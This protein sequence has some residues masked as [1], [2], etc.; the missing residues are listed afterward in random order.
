MNLYNTKLIVSGNIVEAYHYQ[1]PLYFGYKKISTCSKLNIIKK[2]YL[3]QKKYT[4][5]KAKNKIR[6]LINSNVNKYQKKGFRPFSPVFL[7]LT[8]AENIIDKKQALQ[9]F[10]NFIKRLNYEISKN[11]AT[12]KYSA[13]AEYQ[14]RGSVHF[15]VILYNFPFLRAERISKIWSFGYIKINKIEHVKQIGA[16]VSKYFSKDSF[17]TL[18]KYQKMFYSSQ[19]LFLPKSSVYHFNFSFVL[20]KIYANFQKFQIFSSKYDTLHNGICNYW[21]FCTG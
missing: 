11:K 1:K 6:R 2:T 15:H 19:G 9:N 12:L 21:Q 17:D 14:Q 18:A 8:H 10:K 5:N 16:Y 4:F 3:D 7:T 13:V 20:T